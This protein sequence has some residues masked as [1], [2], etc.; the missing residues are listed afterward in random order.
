MDYL[1]RRVIQL[2]WVN[3]PKDF[4]S[5]IHNQDIIN[6]NLSPKSNVTNVEEIKKRFRAPI[7]DCV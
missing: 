6:R 4:F 2:V 7:I 1:L 5:Y 3:M